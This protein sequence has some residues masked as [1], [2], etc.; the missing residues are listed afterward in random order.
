MTVVNAFENI[1]FSVQRGDGSITGEGWKYN[2]Y[3]VRS[4]DTEDRSFYEIIGVD[5]ASEDSFWSYENKATFRFLKDL[6]GETVQIYANVII[7]NSDGEEACISKPILKLEVRDNDCPGCLPICGELV[8]VDPCPIKGQILTYKICCADNYSKIGINAIEF[9]TADG[10]LYD[11]ITNTPVNYTSS[12]NGYVQV[13]TLAPNEKCAYVK[14]KWNSNATSWKIYA[15]A[16]K[17]EGPNILWSQ[18]IYLE[19][20]FLI[21]QIDLIENHN[22]INH[23]HIEALLEEDLN[24]DLVYMKPEDISD[25]YTILELDNLREFT[26]LSWCRVDYRFRTRVAENYASWSNWI[27]I[28]NGTVNSFLVTPAPDYIDWTGNWNVDRFTYPL[29]GYP[30]ERPLKQFWPF[31]VATTTNILEI[32]LLDRLQLADEIEIEYRV[33][34]NNRNSNISG[35]VPCDQ[36]DVETVFIRFSNCDGIIPI[37]VDSNGDDEFLILE[38]DCEEDIP[39]I[40]KWI[41]T[42]DEIIIC[43]DDPDDPGT[44]E[45]VND[46][47]IEIFIGNNTT[48]NPCIEILIKNNT[49]K[50]PCIE[51]PIGNNTVDNPCIEIP[52]MNN[53]TINSWTEIST[54]NVDYKKVMCKVSYHTGAGVA[55]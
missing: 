21:P 51:I 25:F 6:P 52:I 35:V 8:R 39:E 4:G 45:P 2:W 5:K 23:S 43:P 36:E 42:V 47:C 38:Y 34:V 19:E 30:V 46:P 29:N 28:E 31:P 40:G 7:L 1:T 12:N 33:S 15:R 26:D 9:S 49:T 50:N 13:V 18:I 37:N 11:Y 48:E 54:N 53:T 32:E 41:I 3:A 17:F 24:D 10:V 27:V 16:K 14:V 22:W 20:N 44:T 55:L